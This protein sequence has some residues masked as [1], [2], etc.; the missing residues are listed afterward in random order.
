MLK[1]VMEDVAFC[2]WL[3]SCGMVSL[4]SILVAAGMV[5]PSLLFPQFLGIPLPQLM[6]LWD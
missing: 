2:D 3:V 6:V 1:A 5:A 4:K